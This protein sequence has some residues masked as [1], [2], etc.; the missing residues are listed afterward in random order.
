MDWKR[1]IKYV[2]KNLEVIAV[3]PTKGFTLPPRVKFERS[4]ETGA[5]DV[6][7]F[8]KKSYH[9][10]TNTAVQEDAKV[11]FIIDAL[12]PNFKDLHQTWKTTVND[13]RKK[14]RSKKQYP[15]SRIITELQKYSTLEASVL[16]SHSIGKRKLLVATKS[17]QRDE[18]DDEEKPSKRHKTDDS[19]DSDRQFHFYG[20]SRDKGF[21][22]FDRNRRKARE[23]GK[24][25]KKTPISKKSDRSDKSDNRRGDKGK[26]E[27]KTDRVDKSDIVCYNCNKKGYYFRECRSKRKA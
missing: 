15:S 26:S 9:F 6:T 8:S 23:D 14:H 7:N 24:G 25:G 1:Y 12:N 27:K 2:K 20:D 5:L 3:P 22:N 21:R 19:H 11:D 16:A 10:L 13:F 4:S 18:D 17:I